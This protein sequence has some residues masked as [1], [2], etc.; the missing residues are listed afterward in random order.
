MELTVLLMAL[1]TVVGLVLLVLVVFIAGLLA[2]YPAEF[3]A[4][5]L[6]LLVAWWIGYTLFDVLGWI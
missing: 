2:E 4:I 1:A 5:V 6:I 3:T